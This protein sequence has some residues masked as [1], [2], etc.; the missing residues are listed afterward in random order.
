MRKIHALSWSLPASI[1]IVG[2]AL[3]AVIVI[4]AMDASEP[5]ESHDTPASTLRISVVH[6]LE[7]GSDAGSRPA[8]GQI[9]LPFG[10]VGPWETSGPQLIVTGNTGRIVGI[11]DVLQGTLEQ[12]DEGI[13]CVVR[14]EVPIVDASSFTF[15][16]ADVYNETVTRDTLAAAGWVYEVEVDLP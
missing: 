10:T 6:Y 2:I 9:C 5:V 8:E 15:A 4:C 12:L 14:A 11:V 7:T 3:I 1:T 16:L 13:G